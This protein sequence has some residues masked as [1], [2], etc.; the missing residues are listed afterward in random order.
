[1]KQKTTFF[2]SPAFKIGFPETWETKPANGTKESE[3]GG[4][5]LMKDE[6]EMEKIA[7]TMMIGDFF[8]R[9]EATMKRGRKG[10]YCKLYSSKIRV[11]LGVF[12]WGVW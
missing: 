12:F 1:M 7:T 11:V 8:F 6:A 9:A 10:I 5:S 4:V 2:P 3:M